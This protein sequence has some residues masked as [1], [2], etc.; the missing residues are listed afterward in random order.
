MQTKAQTK[1]QTANQPVDRDQ[2]G[3]SPALVHSIVDTVS[4][5]FPTPLGVPNLASRLVISTSSTISIRVMRAMAPACAALFWAFPT[6]GLG[7][8]KVFC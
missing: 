7:I 2:S 3:S 1:V 4:S 6:N 5:L 8:I